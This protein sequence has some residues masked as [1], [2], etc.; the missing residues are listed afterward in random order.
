MDA[1]GFLERAGDFDVYAPDAVLELRGLHRGAAEIRR[2]LAAWSGDQAGARVEIHRAVV[3]TS[4]DSL[5]DDWERVVD[6]RLE[7]KGI[8]YWRFNPDGQV[9]EHRIYGH[10]AVQ[11]GPSLRDR[12]RLA[13]AHPAAGLALLRRRRSD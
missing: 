3:S 11:P 1:Q 13:L 9:Y 6:G 4:D 8:E 10:R 2:A 7:S 12:V 5:V